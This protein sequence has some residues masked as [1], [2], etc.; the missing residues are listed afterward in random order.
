MEAEKKRKRRNILFAVVILMIIALL[1]LIPFLLDARQKSESS[2]AS[3]LSVKAA[4]GNIQKT[5]SGTGTLEEQE[6]DEI[7]V[8]QGVKVTEYLVKNGQYVKQGDPVAVVD[9]VSVMETVSTVSEAMAELETEI[10]TIRSGSDYTYISVPASGRIKAVYAAAGDQVQ[11]VILE[12]GALAV[13]S[14]DGLMAVRFPAG[15]GAAAIG[16]SVTVVLS[17]GTEVTGKVRTV[18]DGEVTVTFSDQYGRIGEEAEIRDQTGS[19]LG[20]GALF[21]HTPWKAMATGGTVANVY[22]MEG[23][24]ISAYG[25]MFVLSGTA[26]GGN[27]EELVARHR[28]Y[29]ETTASLFQM[30]QDGTLTD[31]R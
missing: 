19:L 9:K 3:I 16:Q 1:T 8:P 26:T 15:N 13:L 25:T 28:D 14:L 20:S 24:T 17:D 29:E 21:V 30:Y 10:Q 4:M 11:D 18:I 12:H 6:A 2:S 7:S 27:Y 5:L 23:R 31:P 22:A